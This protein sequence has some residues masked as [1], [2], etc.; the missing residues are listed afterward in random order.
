MQR[1]QLKVVLLYI[2]TAEADEALRMEAA[3]AP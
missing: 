2:Q 1:R 3:T